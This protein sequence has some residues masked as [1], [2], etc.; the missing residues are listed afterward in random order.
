MCTYIAEQAYEPDESHGIIWGNSK[1]YLRIGVHLRGGDIPD[2]IAGGQARQTPAETT[3]PSSSRTVW[4]SIDGR[5]RRNRRC[6]SH[7]LSSRW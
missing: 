2:R 7:H 1:A 6:G 4:M 5:Q 3:L